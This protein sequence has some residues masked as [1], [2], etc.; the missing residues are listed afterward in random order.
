MSKQQQQKPETQVDPFRQLECDEDQGLFQKKLGKIAKAQA[1]RV[2][3]STARCDWNNDVGFDQP[4]LRHRRPDHV[5]DVGRDEV[6]VM[7]LRQ[8]IVMLVVA[9]WLPK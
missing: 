1:R 7:P 2:F 6:R 5:G 8:P 3:R 4:E 9:W